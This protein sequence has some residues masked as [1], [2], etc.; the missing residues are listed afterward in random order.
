MFEVALNFWD[1]HNIQ[2]MEA[3]KNHHMARSALDILLQDD[4]TLSPTQTMS[5]GPLSSEAMGLLDDMQ[6]G[7]QGTQRN[8]NDTVKWKKY[9]T[10]F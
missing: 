1:I 7:I 6:S 4:C 9:N 8:L 10:Y 2:H 5:H 3:L